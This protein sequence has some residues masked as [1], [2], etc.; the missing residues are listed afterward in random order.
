MRH[1]K[2]YKK[3]GRPT[4]HR[5]MMF[6]NMVTSLILQERIVTTVA[7][8]K[9]ARKFADKMI[10]LAKDGSLE[11]R[12]RA[13]AFLM[14]KDAVRKLFDE[15]AERY[16]ERNGGYTRV[17]R[18][19]WRRGDG[20]EQAILELVDRVEKPK[21]KEEKPEKKTPRKTKVK[22]KA[23]E[24]KAEVK[25]EEEKKPRESE[26]KKRRRWRWFFKKKGT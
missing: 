25:P 19:G 24:K 15:L 11:S 26:E 18:L 10:T 13:H 14:R 16:K 5:M 8:A 1:R 3:L 7:K 17:I 2:G 21:K 22:A 20:A 23:K 4:Q 12:R 6:R 9:E